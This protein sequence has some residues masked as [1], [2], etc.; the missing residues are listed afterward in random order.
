[1]EYK[2][3]YLLVIPE[4]D[5]KVDDNEQNERD[6]AIDKEIEVGK[7]HLALRECIKAE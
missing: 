3:V 7:I 6:E 4:V 2:A 1:M 5:P